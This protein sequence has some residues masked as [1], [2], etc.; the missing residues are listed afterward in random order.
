MPMLKSSICPTYS[1][2]KPLSKLLV[3]WEMQTVLFRIWIQLGKSISY[4][5]NYYIMNG[6][7]NLLSNTFHLNRH[8]NS[9]IIFFIPQL[10][11]CVYIYIYIY[12]QAGLHIW[13]TAHCIVSSALKKKKKLTFSV[14]FLLSNR[15]GSTFFVVVGGCHVPMNFCQLCSNHW[16]LLA[17]YLLIL[18]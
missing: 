11:V 3:L 18:V 9:L 8:L 14:L 6:S 15:K 1:L 7:I 2:I 17:C 10:C 16:R 13:S 5:I 12:T 4:N